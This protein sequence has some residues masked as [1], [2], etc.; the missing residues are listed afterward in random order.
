MIWWAS[1]LLFFGVIQVYGQGAPS[2][3]APV[4]MTESFNSSTPASSGAA[5][6][7]V[8]ATNSPKSWSITAGN[9]GGDFTI[10]SSGVI[11]FTLQGAANYDGRIVKKNVTLMVEATNASGSGRGIVHINAYADGSANA[12]SGSA[13]YPTGL[14]HY[15][16]RPP[17][18]VAGFDYYVGIQSG[19]K[20]TPA[21]RISNPSVTIS[22][23]LL[24]CTG[25]NASVTLDAIDFT[26]YAI[27]IPSGGCSSLIVMNSNFGCTGGV[28]PSFAFIQNQ[29]NTTLDI[30]RNKFDSYTDCND[31]S[32]NNVSDIIQCGE[33]GNCTIKYNWFY[34]QSERAVDGGCSPLDYQF[35]LFDNPNT[36]ALA[37]ENM[38]QHGCGRGGLQTGLLVAFNSI[39]SAV[40]NYGGEGWQFEGASG[41][42]FTSASPTIAYNTA[43]A[44]KSGGRNSMSYIVHGFC[45]INSDCSTTAV[46][47]TGT[48][49]FS[50]N[51][52][53]TT[54]A[55]G[56]FYPGART[57]MWPSQVT[58]AN[59]INMNTGATM[60]PR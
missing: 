52:F 47:V 48:A 36:I 12:P 19:T 42:E 6:G 2:G 39:Y 45:H 23:G 43:I 37:H 25:P 28:S 34:H 40:S 20:L 53:D 51:Y 50:D 24:K 58:F 46:T 59:N 21:S 30:E 14:S 11:A 32:P 27:Y 60:T 35:N 18:K 4:V 22:D 15:R 33:I 38:L 3:G 49:T 10:S 7:T 56:A 31:T 57:A 55:F 13:Q 44:L 17:W 41:Q 54:G 8:S 5:V 16:V 9:S 1:S 29:N 26:G